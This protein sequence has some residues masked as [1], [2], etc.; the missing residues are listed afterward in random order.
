MIILS[1][2]LLRLSGSRFSFFLSQPA[3]DFL[4][5]LPQPAPDFL[6]FLSQPAPD[7]LIFLSQ[8]AFFTSS[9]RFLRVV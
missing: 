2:Q 9:A 4:I 7:F 5:F 8:P 6:I 1:L 3:P